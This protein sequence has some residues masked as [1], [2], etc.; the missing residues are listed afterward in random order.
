MRAILLLPSLFPPALHL[1]NLLASIWTTD[2][3]INKRSLYV[4][5]NLRYGVTPICVAVFI[6]CTSA[7]VSQFTQYIF[8]CF[9]AQLATVCI[10][11]SNRG[12]WQAQP[13]NAIMRHVF[14]VNTGLRGK[15]NIGPRSDCC[16]WYV[17]VIG[18]KVNLYCYQHLQKQQSN[19]T[20]RKKH[21]EINLC[22]LLATRKKRKSDV[23]NYI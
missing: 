4:W 12:L 14:V 13:R 7:E 1:T 8:R 22:I 18:Y 17:N 20:M 11:F 15:F 6:I 9:A 19:L 10:L 16:S 23:F 21:Q 2:I 5:N 3:L